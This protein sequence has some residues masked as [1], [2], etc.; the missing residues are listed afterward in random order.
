MRL[1]PL[2]P[3]FLLIVFI[4]PSIPPQVQ[5]FKTAIEAACLL[6]RIDDI[7]SGIA[8]KS[9]PSAGPS[10]QGPQ[11]EDPDAVRGFEI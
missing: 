7:V 2:P 11:T 10:M 9:R 8:K 3:L 4:A 1:K 5:T 6:L